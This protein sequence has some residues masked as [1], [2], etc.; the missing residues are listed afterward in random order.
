MC[1]SVSITAHIV[2][3]TCI[4]NTNESSLSDGDQTMADLPVT[5]NIALWA[6]ERLDRMAPDDKVYAVT[7]HEMER[8]MEEYERLH[9]L[10]VELGEQRRKAI[11]EEQT[12]N[13]KNN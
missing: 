10:L 2:D 11:A 8:A 6:R 3:I 5:Y 13:K 12:R 9:R 4:S 7:F 1:V